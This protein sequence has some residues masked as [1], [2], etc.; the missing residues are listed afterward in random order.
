L[1]EALAPIPLLVIHGA[2]SDLLSA[3]T[4]TGMA[5]RNPN[6]Q[7]ITV[8]R[9]GHAPLLQLPD[10]VRQVGDFVRRVDRST[11]FSRAPGPNPPVQP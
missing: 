4:L 11:E 5:E 1:F 10:L 9:Q 7:T 3:E 6:L 2:L 8:A